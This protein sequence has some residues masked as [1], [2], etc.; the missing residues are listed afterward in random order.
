[1]KE[2]ILLVNKEGYIYLY[3][4]HYE[5]KGVEL[6]ESHLNT[7]VKQ[8][9]FSKNKKGLYPICSDYFGR[10]VELLAMWLDEAKIPYE[11]Y[12]SNTMYI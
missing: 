1:M 4:K 6:P 10:S 11:W 7:Y 3:R 5:R 9:E 2:K 8:F 12:E